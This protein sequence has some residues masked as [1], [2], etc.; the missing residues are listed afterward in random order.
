MQIQLV[1]DCQRSAN[2][3]SGMLQEHGGSTPRSM[4]QKDMK[5]N[6]TA[7]HGRLDLEHLG[8]IYFAVEKSGD[9]PFQLK[10]RASERSAYVALHEPFNHWLEE[11]SE[12][13]VAQGELSQGDEPIIKPDRPVRTMA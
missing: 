7:L 9:T 5:D 12:L 4:I 13:T 6:Q 3:N 10:V 1:F 2:G 11:N 8:I